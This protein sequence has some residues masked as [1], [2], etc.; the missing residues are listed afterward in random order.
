MSLLEQA[1][2]DP[3]SDIEDHDYF[4]FKKKERFARIEEQR[5][6][7][8]QRNREAQRDKALVWRA[9]GEEALHKLTS[10]FNDVRF[11]LEPHNNHKICGN[12]LLAYSSSTALA[13][14]R[15]LFRHKC[16][17]AV[18]LLMEIQHGAWNKKFRSKA[19]LVERKFCFVREIHSHFMNSKLF[20]NEFKQNPSKLR[21]LRHLFREHMRTIPLPKEIYVELFKRRVLH[22]EAVAKMKLIH[23]TQAAC[24]KIL[25]CK[26]VQHTNPKGCS[27][28]GVVYMH[29]MLD[30]GTM[31]VTSVSRD[32][33]VST[34]VTLDF[35]LETLRQ[36]EIIQEQVLAKTEGELALFEGAVFHQVASN[37]QAW[38]SVVLV[39]KRTLR[40]LPRER[41]SLYQ[42]RIR[43]LVTLKREIDTLI[44]EAPPID[45]QYCEDKYWD[46]MTEMREYVALQT[47]LKRQRILNMSRRF[48][49][50]I[51]VLVAEGRERR[52]QE[53]LK[54]QSI[55]PP[56]RPIVFKTVDVQPRREF[57]CFR[58]ECKMRKFIT[59]E[60][61]A[62]HMAVHAKYDRDQHVQHAQKM[63]AKP[64]RD[65]RERN[66]LQRIK[67]SREPV[68][69]RCGEHGVATVDDRDYSSKAADDHIAGG[70]ESKV[71]TAIE[72]APL[73]HGAVSRANIAST[74]STTTRST[75][76]AVRMPDEIKTSSEKTRGEIESYVLSDILYSGMKSKASN[77][78]GLRSVVGRRGSGYVSSAD[79]E[80]ITA[81]V[82][83]LLD[84][85]Q[86]EQERERETTTS[87]SSV[88]FEALQE[89]PQSRNQQ[90]QQQRVQ[91]GAGVVDAYGSDPQPDGWQEHELYYLELV[92]QRAEVVGAPRCISLRCDPGQ[93]T[94]EATRIEIRGLAQ[95]PTQQAQPR[96]CRVSVR[97]PYGS[98]GLVDG[99]SDIV[100][101]H[102]H[103]R[104]HK[105]HEQYEQPGP[106]DLVCVLQCTPSTVNNVRHVS[107][108]AAGTAAGGGLHSVAGAVDEPGG[109]SSNI[110]VLS[111]STEIC[112]EDA[113]QLEGIKKEAPQAPSS[114][115]SSSAS[116]VARGWSV[117]V[118]TPDAQGGRA[119]QVPA[120]APQHQYHQHD[121]HSQRGIALQPGELVCI[122]VHSS[123]Q[124]DSTI[125]YR[126]TGG[127]GGDS[128]LGAS[129]PISVS[130]T[131]ANAACVVYRMCYQDQ[132]QD[133]HQEMY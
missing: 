59:A 40:Y 76:T 125:E 15:C 43:R 42:Y 82:A 54:L 13:A 17:P 101:D 115:S 44:I 74:T 7:K 84:R 56:P 126:G 87:S 122:G 103:H 35:E 92:S 21:V 2:S 12:H 78:Q 123:F 47:E 108:G 105:Q 46:I 39:W 118:V 36:E 117:C 50:I 58:L 98:Y 23:D 114:S 16:S 110:P 57:V 95:D 69:F 25:N 111:I 24:D 124:S 99:C 90:Q 67:A 81:S 71:N 38:W 94:T 6:Q 19:N 51:D 1:L 32:T 18:K 100:Q 22:A 77:M 10:R 129:S 112:L 27:N 61:F 41:K 53:W 31:Y 28:C 96:S 29:G 121:Q 60:R 3:L 89:T 133:Q 52:Y 8:E 62:I 45:M 73:E 70:Y 130:P 107:T 128:S 20:G 9:D 5:K 106:P 72:E 55:I 86:L 33:G 131:S 75:T 79:N 127:E 116:S 68:A 120:A 80:S 88:A 14:K 104:E 30:G 97:A 66:F 65:Q 83:H 93:A 113:D 109:A 34:L 49:R 119:V 132:F 102:F 26:S 4:E 48:K 85:K 11:M 63:K 64:W 91:K 37:I